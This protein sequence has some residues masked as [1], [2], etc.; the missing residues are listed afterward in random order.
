MNPMDARGIFSSMYK[1]CTQIAI[2]SRKKGPSVYNVD[3]DFGYRYPTT[4]RLSGHTIPPP[5]SLSLKSTDVRNR[6]LRA[7]TGRSKA[8]VHASL[9]GS[10]LRW[11]SGCPN[12]NTV[13]SASLVRFAGHGA[14]LVLVYSS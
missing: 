9:I 8:G 7:A 1:L 6:S 2:R 13:C 11:K 3:L 10:L 4:V 14:G 12:V 5:G